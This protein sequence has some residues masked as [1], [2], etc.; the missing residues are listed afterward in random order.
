MRAPGGS[1]R[2]LHLLSITSTRSTNRRVDVIALL[3]QVSIYFQVRQID[4]SRYPEVY[5]GDNSC[6]TVRL[7]E[8]P[9][10]AICS[11][12]EQSV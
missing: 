3:G 7:V 1:H 10:T 2:I 8:I 9:S 6:P 4:E 12:A 11:H 5:P